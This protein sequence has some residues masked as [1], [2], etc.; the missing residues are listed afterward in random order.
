MQVGLSTYSYHLAF[1][2]H[3]DRRADGPMTLVKCLKRAK[4]LGF[5]A[6]QIDPAHFN[7]ERDNARWLRSM[8]ESFGLALQ[9]ASAGIE[10]ERLARDITLAAEWGSAVVCTF[11]GWER[12]QLGR[13]PESRLKEAAATLAESL[14][15]ANRRGVTIAV[16]NHGDI[17]TPD[18]LALVRL[19]GSDRVGVCLDVAN[20]MTF[21]E[22]PVWTTEQLAPYAI[23]CH[24]KDLRWSM[25]NAG[26]K[27][28]GVPLGEGSID[29]DG[30][31]RVLRTAPR[32]GHA[33]LECT[34][35]ALGSDR[36][37]LATEDRAVVKS[38]EFLKRHVLQE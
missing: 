30:V 28:T 10:P 5:A 19:V 11:L 34:T 25:T 29:L 12:P 15:E 38:V 27:L 6:V 1:G 14:P 32:L 17:A 35:E 37:T 26:A 21:L 24:L 23:T 7:P 9:P 31:V 2:K 13:H 18:L 8:A 33:M 36:E 22:E 20:S 16:E 3:P 4:E